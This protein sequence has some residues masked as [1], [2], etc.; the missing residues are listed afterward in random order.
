MLATVANGHSALA[1]CSS[2]K[3]PLV[4][5]GHLCPIPGAVP[6]RETGPGSPIFH[7]LSWVPAQGGTW[8]EI[9]RDGHPDV[10]GAF[11]F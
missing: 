9:L 10:E 5:S 11:P 1:L 4:H 2:G 3:N 8:A 6:G 7:A